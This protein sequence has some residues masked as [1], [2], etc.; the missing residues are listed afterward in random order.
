MGGLLPDVRLTALEGERE[1]RDPADVIAAL[2][3]RGRS[4]AH[5]SLRR[6]FLRFAGIRPGQRVLEVGAGSGVVA[7][8]LAGMVRPGGAVVGVDVNPTFT[9]VA[10]RLARRAGITRGL[11]FRV[12]D[13]E[14]LPFPD[15]RFDRALAMTVLLHVERPAAVL[16][17]MIRV[18]RTGGTVGA[19]DQDFGTLA[20]THPDRALTARILEAGATHACVEPQSGRRLRG[21]FGAAGL[22]DVR[23]HTDVYQDTTLEAYTRSFLERR[24]ELAVR[25]G[26]TG[27]RGAQGWLDGLAELARAGDFVM[28]L[29]YYGVR[30]TKP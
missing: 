28:T 24:A 3:D 18:T 8:E 11:A 30:G 6:R 26:V 21:L 14:R 13:G 19:Q 27:P 23:L 20:L 15:C 4:A 5:A 9:A 7:R 17:E 25:L 29:N 1:R 12:A 2:E 10:R 16:R 22:R